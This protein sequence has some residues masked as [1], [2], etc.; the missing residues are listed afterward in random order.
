MTNELFERMT[1]GLIR[2]LSRGVSGEPFLLHEKYDDAPEGSSPLGI[3]LTEDSEFQRIILRR[4]GFGADFWKN[5]FSG[6]DLSDP[7]SRAAAK[8]ALTDFLRENCYTENALE[9]CFFVMLPLFADSRSA[10]ETKADEL[11]GFAS[12]VGVDAAQYADVLCAAEAI[13][14]RPE[15]INFS[16]EAIIRRYGPILRY[17]GIPTKLYM[18]SKCCCCYDAIRGPFESL[19]DDWTCPDCGAGKDSYFRVSGAYTLSRG[20]LPQLGSRDPGQARIKPRRQ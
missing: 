8:A 10:F 6:S 17:M 14:T 2:E 7:A 13:F 18:C 1:M 16:T 19:P 3:F 15:D 5:D 20:M 12:A 4:I 11:S 9:F